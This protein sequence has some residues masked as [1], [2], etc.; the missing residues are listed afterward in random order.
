M[1]NILK[2]I[3]NGIDNILSTEY[4]PST[5]ALNDAMSDDNFKIS[6]HN[7]YP[8]YNNINVTSP[9]ISLYCDELPHSE[10]HHIENDKKYQIESDQ[11]ATSEKKYHFSNNT[12]HQTTYDTLHIQQQDPIPSNK[13]Y[14]MKKR[15]FVCDINIADIIFLPCSDCV[16]CSH[17]AK[18]WVQNCE[19][20]SKKINVPLSTIISCPTCSNQIS[21]TCTIKS[22]NFTI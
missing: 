18:K 17:C 6:N 9:S 13:G 7:I 5:T 14:S 10:Q 11:Y 20:I 3:I 16:M 4:M 21:L 2:P 22:Q 8:Y 1:L 15:C 19:H 12:H